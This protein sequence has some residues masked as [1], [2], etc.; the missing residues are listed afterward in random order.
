MKVSVADN[1]IGVAPENLG[2]IFQHG[3]TTKK[4][5]HGFGLHSGALAAQQM[6]GPVFKGSVQ[7]FIDCVADYQDAKAKG[8]DVQAAAAVA[9][10][11]FGDTL[12]QFQTHVSNSYAANAHQQVPARA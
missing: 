1:G 4:D 2:R 9:V 11:R 8:G 5:G 10:T 6:G 7:S 3:F 12:N